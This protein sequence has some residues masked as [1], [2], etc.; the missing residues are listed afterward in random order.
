MWETFGSAGFLVS[1]VC[2]PDYPVLLI[3]NDAP[4]REL[5]NCVSERLNAVLKYLNLMACTSLPDYAENDINTVT[6]IARIMVQD[7]ADVFGVIEQRGFD[8]PKQQ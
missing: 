2:E 5:H 8:T 6:N 3:D 1:S 4:L 7:V